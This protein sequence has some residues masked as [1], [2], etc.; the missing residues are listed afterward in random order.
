ME[1]SSTNSYYRSI[2][3]LVEYAKEHGLVIYGAGSWGEISYKIFRLFNVLPTFFCDDDT[4]KQ[5]EFFCDGDIKI[6]IISL[7]EAV[8]KEPKAVYFSAVH[9]FDYGRRVR[10]KM[11]NRLKELGVLSEYSGFHPSR[12]LFL[13]N[14]GIDALE[15]PELDNPKNFNV[16]NLNN[17]IIFNHMGNSGSIFFNTSIDSHPNIINIQ[18]IIGNIDLVYINRLQYLSGKELVLEITSILARNF[19]SDYFGRLENIL[20][21]YYVDENGNSESRIYIDACKFISSLSN[22]LKNR[23]K[24]SFAVLIKAIFAAYAN[25]TGKKCE[26]ETTYWIFC[27]MHR[28]NFDFGIDTLIKSNDFVRVEYLF[29]I[30]EPVQLLFS[31]LNRGFG[32]KEK[33]IYNRFN[34]EAYR[35]LFF[36]LL[37]LMLEKTEKTN[38]KS[39]KVV[40]FE[41]V[42][43]KTKATMKAVCQWMNIPFDESMMNTTVNGIPVYFPAN[44]QDNQKV[45]SSR[46]I[47][48]VERKD[49]SEY[50]SSYD[51]FRLNLAFQNFKRAY[52]YECDIPHYSEFS[53]EFLGELYKYPFRFERTIEQFKTQALNMNILS[54]DEELFC[55]ETITDVILEYMR[56]DNHELITDVITPIEEDVE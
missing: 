20:E 21:Q 25:A 48:A 26:P 22:I 10:D 55:H 33:A 16:E 24:V 15:N 9:H 29:I 27:E 44:S 18:P 40:K 41:D 42:K 45:I 38:G 5:G 35:Q 19:K 51:I 30:R 49:F 11:N 23:E 2:F 53:T 17:L 47:T 28:Q 14:G 12:Y 54:I 6:P 1:K 3:A 56:K 36:S 34:S 52:G 50:F 43:L 8:T 39:I 7:E 13:L 31:R 37:G 32:A 46:D 4:N